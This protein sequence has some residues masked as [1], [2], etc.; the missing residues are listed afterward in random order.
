MGMIRTYHIIT[1]VRS[2]ADL[3][4][5][6]MHTTRSVHLRSIHLHNYLNQVGPHV[7]WMRGM[8]HQ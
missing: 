2:E 4:L 6:Q 5:V 8:W 1:M 3:D 7:H